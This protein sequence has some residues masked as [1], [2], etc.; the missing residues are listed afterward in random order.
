MQN[1]KISIITV[2]KNAGKTLGRCIESVIAQKY[3]NTEYIII[4]GGST[5]NTRQII[6]S[7]NPHIS[8][9][10]SEP[11]KGIYDAMNKGI[12]I[13]TGDIIGMLNADDFFASNDILSCVAEAFS[14]QNADVLYGNL[15]YINQNGAIIRNWHS[16]TYIQGTFNWGW[17]P[18][19][20]TFYCKRLL[21]E[22]LGLYD[23]QYGTAA[24]YELM[25]RFMHLNKLNVCYLNKAMVKMNIGG[26]SNKT[27]QNRLKAWRNDFRAMRN[28][29]VK[30]PLLC[31]IFKPLRKIT[32][33][34][35][36]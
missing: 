6:N 13:A 30:F 10:I 11:D 3:S 18:P 28:N 19:H 2:T 27:Y 20:P 24:D 26:V 7:Y 16:G 12:Q 31:L 35:I 1:L 23:P 33:F 32:Q 34:I 22:R 15:E 29:E 8:F 4:D 25:L 14:R 36:G 9:Y 21:F 17:M 5:D